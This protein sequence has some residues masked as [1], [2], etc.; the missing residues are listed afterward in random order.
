MRRLAAVL[1]FFAWAAPAQAKPNLSVQASPA[2]G[3]APLNVTLTATGDAV[4]YHWDLGDKTQADGPI[5]PHQYATGRF[6]ATV[7]GTAADGSTAQA[8]VVITSAQL[9]LSAPKLAT[10]GK[11]A[12]LRG[13]IAPALR[14]APIT[15]YAGATPVKTAKA[16]KKGRFSFRVKQTVPGSYTAHFDVVASNAVA[17]AVRPALDVALP[18]AGMIGRSLKLRAKLR[19]SGSGTMKIRVWRSGHELPPQTFG[20][21]ARLHLSTKRV[22]EY[23]LR[24]VVLPTAPYSPRKKT[25]R[26]SVFLPYLALGAHGPSVRILERRLAQLHYTT[27]GVDG[28]YSYDTADA[29]MA[30]Q[31]LN[32][33]ARTGRVTPDVWRRL[34]S[35]RAPLPRYHSG[36]HFEVNKTK[37]VLFEVNHGRV[38]RV[39]HVS[40]GATGNTP[41]GVWHIY[42]RVPGTLPDGM[43]DSNFFLRGFAIHGYPSVPSYP[44]SHGCVRVPNWVAPLLFASS[45]YGEAV[46]IYY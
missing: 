1:V 46:Y 43:F 7:T 4:T 25:V 16:D 37:Q 33:L 42:S 45:Y 40:T 39:V 13:R 5:V 19:P 2:T 17:V 21:H 18:H 28:F 26:A 8:S 10:Y 23:K 22:A 32:G 9:T 12:T 38:V 41:I 11:K 20:D 27:R 34:Q 14:G 35:A 15:L 44:A 29:V 31:K 24:I 30:F 6:T 36:H 3:P